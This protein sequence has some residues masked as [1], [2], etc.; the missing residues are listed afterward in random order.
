[1]WHYGLHSE[2]WQ[3]ISTDINRNNNNNKNNRAEEAVLATAEVAAK[4][5]A[6]GVVQQQ[7]VQLQP[8]RA[9]L[10]NDA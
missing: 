2:V 7:R 10:R 1:M 5:V 8:L 9:S 4:K 3:W 6:R